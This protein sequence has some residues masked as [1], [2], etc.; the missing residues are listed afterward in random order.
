M[1]APVTMTPVTMTPAMMMAPAT[2]MASELR[3]GGRL[4]GRRPV[5]PRFF[6]L[7]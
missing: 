4:S 5:Q 7:R 3:L 1:M 6:A 2:V